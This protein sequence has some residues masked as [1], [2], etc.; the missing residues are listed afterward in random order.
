MHMQNPFTNLSSSLRIN[1][2]AN[3]VQQNCT[4]PACSG[5]LEIDT[6]I[7]ENTSSR[8]KSAFVVAQLRPTRGVLRGTRKLKHFD[9]VR[10]AGQL[11]WP[12][13]LVARMGKIKLAEEANHDV[14]YNK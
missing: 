14:T 1:N 11:N 12:V 6:E 3:T 5:V 2:L 9:L 10:T 8:F 13:E 4:R 7:T